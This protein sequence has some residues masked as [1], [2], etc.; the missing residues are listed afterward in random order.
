MGS[1]VGTRGWR[2]AAASA[3]AH[4]TALGKGWHLGTRNGALDGLGTSISSTDPALRCFGTS[5]LLLALAPAPTGGSS[6]SNMCRCNLERVGEE[7]EKDGDAQKL[8]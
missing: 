3:P 2:G 1:S 7:L 4:S 8:R 5:A 6:A